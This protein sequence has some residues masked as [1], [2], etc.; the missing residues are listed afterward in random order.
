VSQHT[1]TINST[2]PLQL[3][4]DPIAKHSRQNMPLKR[5]AEAA[6][7]NFAQKATAQTLRF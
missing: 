3:I 4:S 6:P 2:K 7:M 1:K 5:A